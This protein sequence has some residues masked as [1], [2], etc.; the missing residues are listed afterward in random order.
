MKKMESIIFPISGEGLW[1]ANTVAYSSIIHSVLRILL[2]EFC[3]FHYSA[4][5][6]TFMV[7]I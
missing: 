7:Y 3:R 2:V 1:L 6:Q 5:D 4:Q